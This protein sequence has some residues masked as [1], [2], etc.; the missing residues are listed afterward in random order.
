MQCCTER[1]QSDFPNNECESVKAGVTAPPLTDS[2]P[3]FLIN[4][5]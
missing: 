2:S 1:V 3:F 5:S 4:E